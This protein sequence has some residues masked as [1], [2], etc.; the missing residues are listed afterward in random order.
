MEHVRVTESDRD[1]YSD[2]LYDIRKCGYFGRPLFLAMLE[3]D[4]EQIR[5]LML[6]NED[7]AIVNQR[8][9]IKN[10][11]LYNMLVRVLLSPSGEW[12]ENDDSIA[13]VLAT[14]VQLGIASY[15]FV[16]KAIS[17]GY[18]NL[19]HFRE[20]GKPNSFGSARPSLCGN[21]NGLNARILVHVQGRNGRQ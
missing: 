14:R 17:K 19:V 1:P 21:G 20:E 4:S 13:S 5:D 6:S 2:G 15:D 18:G 8:S 7:V 12:T 9:L 16:S 3:P 10:T 11:R